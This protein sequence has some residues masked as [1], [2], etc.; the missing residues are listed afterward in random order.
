MADGWAYY[1]IRCEWCGN[2]GSVGILTE[3]WNRW[4]SRWKGFVGISSPFGPLSE[5][6]RCTEC[7]RRSLEVKKRQGNSHMSELHLK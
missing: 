6:M 4:T 7:G 5:T 2:V 1:D 3:D